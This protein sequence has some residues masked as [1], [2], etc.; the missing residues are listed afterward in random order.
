VPTTP[1]PAWEVLDHHRLAELAAQ[2]F[3]QGAGGIVHRAA[4]RE[5]HNQGY[6][7]LRPGLLGRGRARSHQTGQG[8]WNPKQ[9]PTR[10]S[11]TGLHSISIGVL[12]VV[13]AVLRVFMS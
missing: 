4:G 3:S 13:P 9:E 8:E 7:A 12:H 1:P 6:G 5:G 10:P 11:N 2:A